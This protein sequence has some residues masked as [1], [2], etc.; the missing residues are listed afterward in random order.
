MK[1]IVVC[2]DCDQRYPSCH[3]HC[4]KYAAD[5]KRHEEEKAVVI[6]NKEKDLLYAAY[7]HSR[8]KKKGQT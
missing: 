1:K 2:K 6:K 4:E 8:H 5:K 3:D 7:R